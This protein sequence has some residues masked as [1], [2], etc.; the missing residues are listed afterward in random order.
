MTWGTLLFVLVI[1]GLLVYA[2]WLKH[3]MK[4]K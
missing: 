3:K 2:E 4:G 1:A